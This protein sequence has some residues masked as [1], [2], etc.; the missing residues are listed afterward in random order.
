DDDDDDDDFEY[1]TNGRHR[2]RNIIIAIIVLALIALFIITRCMGNGSS[3]NEASQDSVTVVNDNKESEDI[4]R[5]VL[6]NELNSSGSAI[7][8][9]MRFAATE[10]NPERIIGVVYNNR[11][12]HWY[13]QIYELSK[14]GNSWAYD[15]KVQESIEKGITFD[16]MR[17]QADESKIPQSI[18][19]DGKKYFFYAYMKESSSTDPTT[20]TLKL[21]DPEKS[22]IVETLSYSGNMTQRDG[23]QVIVCDP[24]ANGQS[25]REAMENHARNAIGVLH[26]KT[27]DEIEDEKA[28]EEEEREKEEE[29]REKNSTDWDHTNA[30]AVADMRSGSEVPINMNSEGSR[31]EPP[32]DLKGNIAE[33]KQGN[34]YTVFRTNSGRVYAYNKSTEKYLQVWGSGAKSIAFSSS[35]PGIVY[36]GTANGKVR[37]NLNTGKA[38]IV[39]D[40]PDKEQKTEQPKQPEGNQSEGNAQQNN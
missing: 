10:N 34:T 40:N 18:E 35:E 39:S 5:D 7:A 28:K 8:Y 30:G 11:E 2:T 32:Q 36:I 38:K 24:K 15:K 25:R 6:Q 21:Y 13:Y 3:K 12:S 20:I 26:I 31:T 1:A 9:A 37:A 14:N 27:T 16:R 22:E 33:T 17:M 23:K 4:M 29:E 19:I